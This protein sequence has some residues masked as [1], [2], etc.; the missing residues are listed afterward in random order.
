MNLTF[1]RGTISNSGK[2][3]LLL[4]T[5][6]SKCSTCFFVLLASRSEC[7]LF[8]SEAF[9]WRYVHWRL[10]FLRSSKVILWWWCQRLRIRLGP[11]RESF[12][13]EP[14]SFSSWDSIKLWDLRKTWNSIFSSYSS[15]FCMRLLWGSFWGRVINSIDFSLLWETDE[16]KIREIQSSTTRPGTR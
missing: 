5:S 6:A 4:F 10:L 11:Q 7:F 3:V 13:L 1:F 12:H 16:V 14:I 9:R 8:V 15:M 2:I